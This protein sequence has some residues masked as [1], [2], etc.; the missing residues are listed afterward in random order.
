MNI[1]D[2]Y[3][4]LAHQYDQSHFYP[5]SAAEY[6]ETRRLRLI[7]PYLR[8]SS[9]LK[10]LD[11]ACGT[12]TYLKMAEGF[13]ADVVGCDLSEG[14]VRICRDKGLK[15]LFINDFHHLPFKDKTFDM[16]LCVA[17]ILYS[18]NPMAVLSELCRVLKDNGV[19]ILTYFNTFNFRI[20]NYV[21]RYFKPNHPITHEHRFGPS[22]LKDISNI[23][24]KPAYAC[25]INYLP[26]PANEKPRKRAVLDLFA[27]LEDGIDETKLMYLSNE[28][29]TVLE[30]R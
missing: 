14:M 18:S 26:F 6:V 17:A 5:G 7:S 19:L 4:D 10:V 16:A 21:I 3:D 2:I 28:T 8:K 11:V 9:G 12:G 15:S 24:F 13:G 25:G 1:K 29:F 22:L 27:R 30:K 23:G 20:T